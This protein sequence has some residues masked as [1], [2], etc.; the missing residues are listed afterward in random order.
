MIS[1]Q[2][3]LLNL[4]SIIRTKALGQVIEDVIDHRGEWSQALDTGLLSQE[5]DPADL[6][7]NPKTD[8]PVLSENTPQGF[9]FGG[10]TAVERRNCGKWFAVH[11]ALAE[12]PYN[13]ARNHTPTRRISVGSPAPRWSLCIC[14]ESRNGRQGLPNRT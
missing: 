2:F 11:I 7:Q 10:V 8:Q 6:G 3:D 13:S 12:N 4:A 14:Q 9:H 1:P 5:L